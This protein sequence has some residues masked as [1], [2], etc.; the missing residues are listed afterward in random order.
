MNDLLETI[1]VEGSKIN[2]IAV[3]LDALAN[4]FYATGNEAM[5]EK[6]MVMADTLIES[7]EQLRKAVGEEIGRQCKEAERNHQEMVGGMLVLIET[8]ED[9]NRR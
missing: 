5:A 1:Y 6:L 4:H 8:L 3:R 7:D 2:A 9:E